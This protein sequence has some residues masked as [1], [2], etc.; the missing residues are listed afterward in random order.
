MTLRGV[1]RNVGGGG[2]SVAGSAGDRGARVALKDL[3]LEQQHAWEI[4][5]SLR[6]MN[7]LALRAKIVEAAGAKE[8][9]GA[10]GLRAIAELYESLGMT[11]SATGV[12]RF[13]QDRGLVGGTSLSG[14]VAKGYARA[15]DGDEVIVRVTRKEEAEQLRPS[16][17]A[18][19]GFLRELGKRT[20]AHALT[21]VKKA[22]GLGNPPLP[23]AALELGNEF[24]GVTTVQEIARAT[25]MREI[26]LTREGMRAL[27]EALREQE[28]KEHED[29]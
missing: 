9:V 17:R 6:E 22:L 16:E 12:Q 1:N 23:D 5:E 11:L 20:G 18:V 28:Q 7:E 19:L 14:A 26:P 10:A 8:P 25:T 3:P 2:N 27:V 21:P 4:I 29:K 13:K 15:L 24:V